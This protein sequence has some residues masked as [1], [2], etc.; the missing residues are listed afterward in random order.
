LQPHLNR[1]WRNIKAVNRMQEALELLRH[2]VENLNQGVIVLTRGGRVRLMTTR[3]RQWLLEY[4]EGPSERR[5]SLPEALQRWV[6]YQ[7]TLLVGSDTVPLPPEPLAIEREG[8]YLVVRLLCESDKCLLLLEERRRTVSP[9][10]LKSL[11][12][13][14]REAEVL[15]WVAQ[16]RSNYAIG[17][18]L[19]ISEPTVKKHLEHLYEKLGVWNRTEAAARALAA[20]DLTG[21]C[22]SPPVGPSGER[23]L[24]WRVCPQG[25]GK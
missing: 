9:A 5:N 10:T 25:R 4:F 16:G 19:G 22:P 1:A 7:Q 20:L 21:P 12:L 6:R 23:V 17:V 13:S 11:G 14:R 18:I 24:P 8:K 2:G 15:A 3:A